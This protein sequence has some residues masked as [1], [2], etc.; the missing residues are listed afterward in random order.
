[1]SEFIYVCESFV[2]I[3]VCVTHALYMGQPEEGIGFPG[4]GILGHCEPSCGF[5]EWNQA[6]LQDQVLLTIELP[7]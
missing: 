6:A 1:M 3:H 2:C 4:N 5:W 7:L